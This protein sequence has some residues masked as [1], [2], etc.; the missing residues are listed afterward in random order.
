MNQEYLFLDYLWDLEPNYFHMKEKE[1]DIAFNR[2]L[3][4]IEIIDD[5]FLT[6]LSIKNIFIDAPILNNQLYIGLTPQ[7]GAL[8]EEHYNVDWGNFIYYEITPLGL[9]LNEIKIYAQS[10]THLL[11]VLDEINHNSD[12][13]ITFL[14]SWEPTYWKELQS[15][16]LYSFNALNDEGDEI[17]SALNALTLPKWRNEPV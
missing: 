12:K 8:W 4:S 10:K 15:V 16:Y 3:I 5:L 17:L 6:H 1:A 11:K 9:E 14:E 2:P 7:G 13:N